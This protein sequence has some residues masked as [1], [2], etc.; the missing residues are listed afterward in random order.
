MWFGTIQLAREKG[1]T[2]VKLPPHTTD[3]LQPLDVSVFKSLKDKWGDELF[4]RMK[5]T[6]SRLTKAE[7]LEVISCDKVWAQAFSQENITNG[8]Q[9]CGI[10]PFD[11]SAYP[12]HRFDTNLLNRYNV[13]VDEGKPDLTADELDEI[14]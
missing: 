12:Q 11:P 3:L 13:W 2:I 10:I 7:F 5:M 1:V 14:F 6:R 4:K 8:F 9:K